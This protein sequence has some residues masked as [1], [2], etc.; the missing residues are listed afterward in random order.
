MALAGASSPLVDI[1]L[2]IV[3]IFI[4]AFF[5]ASE[6]A[7]ISLNDNV[8]RR[9]AE[10]GDRLAKRLLKLI[11]NPSGFLAT[12]QV[13][14]TLAGFLSS[15][16]AAD[17]FAIRLS[18][19]LDPAAG[20]SS[21]IYTVSVVAVTLILSFFSLT[22]GEL[23]PKRV[24][25]NNPE[26]IARS[27]SGI[28][29][30][31]GTVLRPFIAFLTFSTNLVLKVL[32]IDPLKNERSVTEE[33]IRIMVDVGRESGTIHEEE[34]EMIENIFDFNDKEVSEIMT[35]RTNIVALDVEA[36]LDEVLEVAVREKY[37]RIPVYEDAID[38]IVGILHIKDLLIIAAEELTKPFSL[39]DMLRPATFVPETKLVDALFREMQRNHAQMAVVI[40]E[41]GGTAGI[42]TLEDM[43]E[44]I[45]GNLQDEYDEEEAEIERRDETTFVIDGQTALDDVAAAVGVNMP[46][47]DYD[48][49]A[50]MVVGLLDR[51]PEEGE[52]PETQFGNLRFKVLEM[53]DR[54][55]SK[56]LVTVMPKNDE[57]EAGQADADD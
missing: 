30:G 17:K 39:R 8:V 18:R 5:S 20:E 44:E 19:L 51:I 50:G 46:E 3:L 15:A 56:I 7:I 16:F 13:G 23:V 47:D 4:N 54:R 27:V 32:G 21:W 22:L 9:Q 36:T 33:E 14:V 45:V 11:E 31:V 6:I 12:I 35:H 28:L 48:T 57:A 38:N 55:V 10:E 42:V 34:K 40:D 25:Q 2:I 29:I 24:A 1:L 53:D 52:Q 41:Y 49:L 26:K 43:I 37:T